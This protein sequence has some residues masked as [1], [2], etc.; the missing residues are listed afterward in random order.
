[1]QLSDVKQSDSVI[2]LGFAPSKSIAPIDR[3]GWDIWPLNELYTEMP[4]LEAR[5]TAWFQLH[6]NEPPQVRD[7]NHKQWLAKL[8]CP[9]LL[10]KRHPEIPNAVPYPLDE[11]IAEFG[12]YFTNSISWM[13]AL[14][15]KL[16]YKRIHLY[17]VDMAQDCLAP[18][19]RVL[20]AD[21]RY[22]PAGELKIGDKLLAFDELPGT[23][24]ADGQTYRKWR[25]ATVESTQ[26]I[27]RPCYRLHLA[28]GTKL[29]ASEGHQWLTYAEHTMRW[30]RTDQLVTPM[31]RAQRPTCL[32][33]LLDVWTTDHS[34]DGGYLAAAFDGEGYISQHGRC[35]NNGTAVTLGFG[36]KANAMLLHVRTALADR[37]FRVHANQE[38]SGGM[39]NL[40]LAGGRSAILR[41]LGEIRPLRLL[42]NFDLYNLGTMHH[43]DAVAVEAAEFIGNQTVVGLRTDTQ[44]L[45][46]E[47]LASHNSEYKT[48]RPSCEYFL[49]WARGKGIELYLPP[50]SDLLKAWTL[51]GLEYENPL[52]AKLVSRHKE[53]EQRRAQLQREMQKRNQENAQLNTAFHQ[54]TGALEDCDYMLKLAPVIDT[55]PAHLGGKEAPDVLQGDE[56]PADGGQTDVLSWGDNAGRGSAETQPE[57]DDQPEMA[58]TRGEPNTPEPGDHGTLTCTVARPAGKRA[59]APARKTATKPGGG[60]AP[61]QDS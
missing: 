7:V 13:I 19:M 61:A 12:T 4:R 25:V 58:G 9:V 23:Q 47:G 21:L 5:A 59:G 57:G 36:Q 2:I 35:H 33:R 8:R 34:R 50:D 22:M 41:F 46:V 28:D 11:I 56:A 1:M 42:E 39:H 26:L 30:R 44:T 45:I 18:E 43:K 52:R 37:G 16:G 49:G 55:A 27:E 31:H 38:T 32:N 20:T 60:E 40:T 51:Y 15:I 53:L 6:G 10:W 14:A 3:P 54:L 48:Q 29:V 24:T 17:G